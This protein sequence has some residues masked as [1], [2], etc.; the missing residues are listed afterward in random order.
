VEV[1]TDVSEV[2]Q[3]GLRTRL[4]WWRE[5]QFD[6]IVNSTAEAYDE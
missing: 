3:G 2:D 4:K 6:S 1:V 5:K